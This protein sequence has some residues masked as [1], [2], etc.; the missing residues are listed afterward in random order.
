MGSQ[1][2]GTGVHLFYR[3]SSGSLPA[4]LM[5][6]GWRAGFDESSVL[7]SCCDQW[8]LSESFSTCGSGKTPLLRLIGLMG[9]RDRFFKRPKGSH[10]QEL[11][12]HSWNLTFIKKPKSPTCRK[13]SKTRGSFEGSRAAGSLAFGKLGYHRD[14]GG[15]ELS[16]IIDS[17]KKEKPLV[18]VG[19][20]G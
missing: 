8:L 12:S 6:W 15:A 1:Q 4:P 17:C 20:A 16:A 13:G 10:F 11:H 19:A 9:L 7:I 18:S 3:N 5:G 2:A 14:L